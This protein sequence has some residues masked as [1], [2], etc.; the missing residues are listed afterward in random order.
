MA[1]IVR[2][3][4]GEAFELR[5]PQY[6]DDD[7]MQLSVRDVLDRLQQVTGVLQNRANRDAMLAALVDV[8]RA[9]SVHSS[10]EFDEVRATVEQALNEGVLRLAPHVV[11]LRPVVD[12]IDVEPEPLVEDDGDEQEVEAT[13]TLEIEL[14]DP[15]GAPVASAAYAV[16]LPDGEVVRGQLDA[17][18]KALLSGIHGGGS[19]KITFTGLD[20][21]AWEAA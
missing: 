5:P 19:C 10:M 13:H 3:Q 14:V 16:E 9:D 21:D 11:D 2:D 17:Q 12:L 6:D 1:E 8:G 20:Q 7:S 18:G 4:Q 15:D